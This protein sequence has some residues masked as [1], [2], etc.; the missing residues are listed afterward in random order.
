MKKTLLFLSITFLIL[1]TG[2]SQ[3]NV[4][5]GIYANT[6]WTKANSPYIVTGDIVVFPGYTLTIQPG[7]VVKFDT[8][9]S[10]EI[11]QST[12]IAVGTPTDSITFTSNSKTPGPGSWNKIELNGQLTS[13]FAYCNFM[14]ATSGL[15]GS[16]SAG[17]DSAYFEHSAF[18]YNTNGI[19]NC[20]LI[21]VDSCNFYYNSAG[22]NG[23]AI[24]FVTSCSFLHNQIGVSE[25][26]NGRIKGCIIEYNNKGMY[27][28]INGTVDNCIIK[29]NY[30]GVFNLNGNYGSA[31]KNTIIDSNKNNGIQLDIGFGN[32]DTIMNC[33]IRYNRV[34]INDSS[35]VDGSIEQSTIQ[36]NI[37]DSNKYGIILD[38][39][40]QI[41]CNSICA[42]S[43]YDLYYLGTNNL[44]V[45]NNYWC[46]TDS[47]AAHAT[48][49]DGHDNITYGLILVTPMDTAP[50]AN[51]V[52]SVKNIPLPSVTSFKLYPNPFTTSTT[53]KFE[54]P[55]NENSTLSVYNFMGQQLISINNITANQVQ[56]NR[57]DLTDGVYFFQLKTDR[58]LMASGKFVIQK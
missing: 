30:N 18:R 40:S 47:A 58:Q 27:S 35:G 45:P 55:K 31:F 2:Y 25:N 17:T 38:E 52:T 54:N 28:L 49:Y 20:Q 4:S 23:L 53:L 43:I 21:N 8:N 9:T 19:Y 10:I 12:I 56:I 6:L 16:P 39:S 44:R 29:Y 46:T 42:N 37:I 13:T 7:V 26:Q 14:Y 11:R 22:I 48:I 5:G 57:G 36:Q 3:T 1:N 15:D 41:S 34:G 32:T 24:G 51:I 33:K 50:C